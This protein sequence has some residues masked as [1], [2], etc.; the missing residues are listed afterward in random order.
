MEDWVQVAKFERMSEEVHKEKS[1]IEDIALDVG[2]L[3]ERVIH[4]EEKDGVIISVHPE[5]YSYFQG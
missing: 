5:F 4:V 1:R 3:P 2:L